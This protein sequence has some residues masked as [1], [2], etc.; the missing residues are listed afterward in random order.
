MARVKLLRRR[1]KLNK[2]VEQLKA[3]RAILL[4]CLG[5]ALAFWVPTKMAQIYRTEK[6][7]K[8]YFDLPPKATFTVVPPADMTIVVEGKGWDLL[9]DRIL[10]PH[11][12]LYFDL[13]NEKR[14]DLNRG[15]LRKAILDQLYSLDLKI[16]E[17]NYEELHFEIEPIAQKKVAVQFDGKMTFARDYYL[18]QALQLRPD[19]VWIKGPASRVGLT[20]QVKTEFKAFDQL[21]A[22]FSEKLELSV[23]QSIE[24]TPTAVVLEASIE[25]FTEKSIFVKVHIPGSVGRLKYFPSQVKVTFQIG[26]SAFNSISSADFLIEADIQEG[27]T[28]KETTAALIVKKQ[29]ARA[30]NVRI[31][32]TRIDF[33][34]IE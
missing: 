16:I 5:I 7:V 21:S 19:S 13:S 17:L 28:S 1:A 4:L 33:L 9:F 11:I 10:D 30:R 31:F 27:S 23:P 18:K 25:K 3:D 24:V 29:P 6:K 26:L 2:Q 34:I 20:N 22:A 12:K 15:Q 32:P 14:F 8:L